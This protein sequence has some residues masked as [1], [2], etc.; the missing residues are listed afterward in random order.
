MKD[1][2]KKQVTKEI[3]ENS[4]IIKITKKYS[5]LREEISKKNNTKFAKISKE[6]LYYLQNEKA[7]EV[8]I[9]EDIDIVSYQKEII[10]SV[11]DEIKKGSN[12]QLDR[13]AVEDFEVNIFLANT[14]ADIICN[15]YHKLLANKNL[16]KDEYFSNLDYVCLKEICELVKIYTEYMWNICSFISQIEEQMNLPEKYYSWDLYLAIDASE[17]ILNY[18]WWIFNDI[19]LEE[20]PYW[21]LI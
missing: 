14:T 8:N 2:L 17:D 15:E 1:I 21:N 16:K 10:E 9:S 6:K 3:I 11:I 5:K 18:I 20:Q 13:K 4:D 19:S 7:E 12:V